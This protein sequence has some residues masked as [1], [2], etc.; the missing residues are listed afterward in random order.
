MRKVLNKPFF[1][2]PLEKTSKYFRK[3]NN[4]AFIDIGITNLGFSI[5]SI[6]TNWTNPTIEYVERVNLSSLEQIDS[7]QKGNELSDKV[8][9]F[10]WHYRSL[11]DKA[12]NIFIERQPFSGIKVVEQLIYKAYKSKA[13]LVSPNSM[14]A[15]Y[16]TNTSHGYDYKKRK[17]H[18]IEQASIWIEKFGSPCAQKQWKLLDGSK[19]DDVSDTICMSKYVFHKIRKDFI[20]I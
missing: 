20:K 17:I 12:N 5:V 19:L 1:D 14:H 10:L 9:R 13:I 8:D 3:R 4:Y 16:G 11:L 7:L 18:A 2:I 15:Y 6:N